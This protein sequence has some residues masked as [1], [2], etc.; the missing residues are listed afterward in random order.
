MSLQRGSPE[1]NCCL[2]W[3]VPQRV[4]VVSAGREVGQAEGSPRDRGR[5]KADAG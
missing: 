4:I 3:E 2:S 1:G 5:R